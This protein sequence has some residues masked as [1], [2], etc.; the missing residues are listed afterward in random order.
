MGVLR[1]YFQGKNT[2]LPTAISQ[3]LEQF[4][5]V[6]VG[7]VAA[8][9]FM[10]IYAD[11]EFKVAYGAAGGTFGTLVGAVVSLLFLG[12]IFFMY[13]PTLKRRFRKD[14]GAVTEDYQT[15]LKLVLI[16]ILPIILNQTLYS[17]S[18]TL[19][20]V[21]L[22]SV[23]DSK[24]FSEETR[25]ILWGRYSSKYRLLA[26][27]PLS[28]TRDTRIYSRIHRGQLHNELLRRAWYCSYAT[29][30]T[31]CNRYASHKQKPSFLTG[32]GT[33]QH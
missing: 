6:V 5:H 27:L 2:M 16:T 21:L 25:L 14:S 20:S 22:N 3:L 26:N 31:H 18:G 10:K 17:V 15:L 7:L 32:V 24:G 30:N 1:G 11:S 33:M 4:V 8:I 13:Y 19:D 12:V 29:C 9:A 23:L 28:A